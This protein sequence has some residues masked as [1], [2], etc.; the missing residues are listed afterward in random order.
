MHG[1][2]IPISRGCLYRCAERL[3]KYLAAKNPRG[4]HFA[5]ASAKQIY[6]YLLQLQVVD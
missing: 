5:T 1:V 6:F 4:A 2:H 3:R